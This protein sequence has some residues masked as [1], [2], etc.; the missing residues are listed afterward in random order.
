M[1]KVIIA[2][3]AKL[4]EPGGKDT[5]LL[6]HRLREGAASPCAIVEDGERRVVGGHIESIEDM[7]P[8]AIARHPG[9]VLRN[10]FDLVK[11]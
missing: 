6:I 5:D 1:E 3:H 9:S 2:I 10:R 8:Y 7:L 4:S 11:V